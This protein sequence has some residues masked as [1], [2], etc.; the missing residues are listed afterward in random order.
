M[1]G[2]SISLW[3]GHGKTPSCLLLASM[4]KRGSAGL[5][6]CYQAKLSVQRAQQ[7]AV[8]QRQ[9]PG[10]GCRRLAG[11]RLKIRG[12]DAPGRHSRFRPQSRP[13]R[14][15]LQYVRAGRLDG[16]A[17]CAQSASARDRVRIENGSTRCLRLQPISLGERG[18]P[19]AARAA[20]QPAIGEFDL[21]RGQM[22]GATSNKILDQIEAVLPAGCQRR[23]ARAVARPSRPSTSPMSTMRAARSTTVPPK[24]R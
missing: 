6:I 2:A 21:G 22:V 20:R 15:R 8:G 19:H 18:D 7:A 1:R 16:S 23:A 14:A 12:R 3:F 24:K 17:S 9:A 5:K 11:K 4:R 13:S 10:P